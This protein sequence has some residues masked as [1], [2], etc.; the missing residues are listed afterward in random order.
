MP[1]RCR[2]PLAVT[3]LLL[4]SVTHLPAQT[5]AVVLKSGAM[6]IAINGRLHTQFNTT[7][8]DDEPATAFELRRIRLE[9]LVKINDVVSGK[10]QPD[11][12]GNR[13]V[14]KDAYMRITLDPGFQILAGQA[15]RPFSPIPFTSST[16][17]LPIERGVRIRGVD[18]A[19]DEYNLVSVLGYSERDVGLQVMGSPRGAPLGLFYQAGIFNGPAR[20]EAGS[21]D[22]YQVGAR[23]AVQPLPNVRV[24]GAWSSRHFAEASA[25]PHAPPEIERGHAWEVDV[26]YGG[27]EPGLH[28]VAEA[29]YGDFDPFAGARFFG[30]QG[31]LAWRTDELASKIV[32][33]EPVLRVSYGDANAN[34]SGP[35]EGG[36]TLVTPGVN[37]YL[38]GLN[39]IMFNYD[40]WNP[41][42]GEKHSSF[43][44]QFQ[45]GF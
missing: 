32:N 33:V 23:L 11:F 5:P 25:D 45:L 20:A 39:R 15:H 2:G 13:V 42:A 29:V 21:E 4:A 34:D 17:I 36:G 30:A 3:F 14:M 7:S 16:R 19:W 44:A 35:E 22:T 24:G 27:Y 18:D 8:V 38:G 26:E 12:A 1:S 37:L 28:V 9:A 41:L 6:E 40:F 31:W 43:K 10:I